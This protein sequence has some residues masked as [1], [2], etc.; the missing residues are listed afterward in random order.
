[1]VVQIVQQAPVIKK[2]VFLGFMNEEVVRAPHDEYPIKQLYGNNMRLFE[3][4][5]K[6]KKKQGADKAA[7]WEKF[8]V[9]CVQ[10]QFEETKK[11]SPNIQ[12]RTTTAPIGT[13]TSS[14]RS[15]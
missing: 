2:P 4:D 7:T 14:A 15:I 12:C 8:H 10:K 3:Y 1:M 13:S 11:Q 5:P 9:S 6:D